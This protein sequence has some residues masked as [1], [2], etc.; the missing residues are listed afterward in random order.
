MPS[1]SCE[2]LPTSTRRGRSPHA[3]LAS[4][5]ASAKKFDEAREEA[6]VAERLEPGW[7]G[8]VAAGAR[9]EAQAGRLDE[10][11]LEYRRA[12][13]EQPKSPVLLSQLALTYH[14]QRNDLEATRV[15]KEALD[16]DPDVVDVRVLLAERALEQHD[17]KEAL[18]QA[19]RAAGVEPNHTAAL[20]CLADA[21]AMGGKKG[22]ALDAYR[23]AL[24][25]WKQ[26]GPQGAPEDRLALVEGAI[27]KNQLPPSRTPAAGATDAAPTVSRSRP[28]PDDFSNLGF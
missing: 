17:A 26:H 22:E 27:A 3:S 21:L 15:A 23:K 20:L 11:I 6:R 5:L 8:A 16:L 12:I 13:A 1:S 24:A 7:A 25:A 10:A 19:S 2:P 4:A 18:S 9:V 14:A 28:S